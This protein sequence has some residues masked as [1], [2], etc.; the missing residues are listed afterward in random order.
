[1]TRL[2]TPSGTPASRYASTSLTPEIGATDDGLKTTVFPA[3]IAAADGP[4]ASAIGKLNGLI[5]ANTP[6]GRRIDRVWTAGSPRL[7]IGW[8]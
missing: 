4:A 5:T 8:S 3:S 1:M 7:S 6:W 2:I